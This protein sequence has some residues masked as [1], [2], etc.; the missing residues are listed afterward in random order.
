M[1]KMIAL[2]AALCLVFTALPVLA[3][4]T[5]A[6]TWY[7][8]TIS[9]NGVEVGASLAGL[10]ITMVLNE[11]GTCVNTAVQNGKTM[12]EKATWT[13]ADGKILFEGETSKTEAVLTDGK[14]VL[15]RPEGTLTFTRTLEETAALQGGA[16]APAAI[17]AESADAF[18]G[19]WTLSGGRFLGIDLPLEKLAE[20]GISGFVFEVTAEKAT[21]HM[22][23]NT[24]ESAVTFA[25][26][27]VQVKITDTQTLTLSLTEDGRMITEIPASQEQYMT[28]YFTKG[29]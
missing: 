21:L 13:E 9:S 3:E 25:D 24:I 26:G 5:A 18:A 6:G 8:A 29:E 23:G 20:S 16:N 28:L 2:L 27:A 19:T 1:R 4:D 7:L 22:G 11:D 14:L 12:E 10:E 15:T 17:Q